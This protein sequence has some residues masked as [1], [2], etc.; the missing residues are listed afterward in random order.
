MSHEP[1]RGPAPG[2]AREPAADVGAARVACT[3]RIEE[4]EGIPMVLA[5]YDARSGQVPV[6]HDELARLEGARLAELFDHYS[7]GLSGLPPAPGAAGPDEPDPTLA[8]AL[9]DVLVVLAD[10]HL[11]EDPDV[12]HAGDVPDVPGAAVVV[13]QSAA[14]AP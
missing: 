8:G 6:V 2:L 7:D 12:P 11:R 5:L 13:V 1:A 4:R 14:V 9:I 10:Q 3:R